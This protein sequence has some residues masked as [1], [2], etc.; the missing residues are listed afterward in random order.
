MLSGG[1]KI[2]NIMIFFH[3]HIKLLPFIIIILIISILTVAKAYHTGLW[4]APS[5]VIDFIGWRLVILGGLKTLQL[6]SFVK[7]YGTYDIVTKRFKPYGFIYPFIEIILGLMFLLRFEVL[8]ASWA[9]FVI[10]LI[11]LTSIYHALLSGKSLRCACLG[12]TFNLPLNYISFGENLL[13]AMLLLMII[14]GL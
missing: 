11:S 9:I 10:I 14:L 8:L 4:M 3:K 12:T 13:I 6:S 7:I 5:L 1:P 2:S